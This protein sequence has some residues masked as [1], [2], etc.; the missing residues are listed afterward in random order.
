MHENPVLPVKNPYF[1]QKTRTL[2]G[3]NPYFGNFGENPV[4]ENP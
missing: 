3:Q 1:R 4:F 2:S